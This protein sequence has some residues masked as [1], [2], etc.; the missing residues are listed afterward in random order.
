MIVS[1]KKTNREQEIQKIWSTFEYVQERKENQAQSRRI[2]LMN[3][4]RKPSVKEH[5]TAEKD[6]EIGCG[7]S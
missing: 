2:L 4:I 1:V 6:G 7:H 5:S 3:N